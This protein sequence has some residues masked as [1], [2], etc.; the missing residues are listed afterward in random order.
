ML[1][2]VQADLYSAVANSG[3]WGLAMNTLPSHVNFAHGLS[4]QPNACRW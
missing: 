2:I 3:M 4:R 1:D